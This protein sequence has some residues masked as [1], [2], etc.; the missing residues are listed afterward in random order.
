MG[1]GFRA[2]RKVCPDEHEDCTADADDS[3]GKA[4]Q[5]ALQ[6]YQH[7]DPQPGESNR[8]QD[9]MLFDAILHSHQRCGGNKCQDEPHAGV[10][11]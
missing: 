6:Q 7:E 11:E 2:D 5:E 10:T 8:L 3:S 4:K 9:G 1:H